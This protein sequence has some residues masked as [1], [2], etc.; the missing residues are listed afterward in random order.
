MDL[1]LQD[2]AVTTIALGAFAVLVRRVAIVVRPARK[3]P[4]CGAC[5]ACEQRPAVS[6]QGRT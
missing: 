5:A 6:S 2:V 3:K 4:A 1:L